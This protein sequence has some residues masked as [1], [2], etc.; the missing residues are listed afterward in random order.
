VGVGDGDREWSE[1]CACERV[2]VRK[3]SM[4]SFGVKKGKK[5]EKEEEK[6]KK[7]RGKNMR[8]FFPVF[9]V[10][11]CANAYLLNSG[12]MLTLFSILAL[13]ALVSKSVSP[14]MKQSSLFPLFFSSLA[15]AW[16][17]F[18]AVMMLLRSRAS[19]LCFPFPRLLSWQHL[20]FFFFFFSLFL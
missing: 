5:E 4:G 15:I 12:S 7:K 20:F 19:V 14:T 18:S 3:N 13:A 10:G 2:C 11:H 17:R 16:S 1:M 6:K 9:V 8:P